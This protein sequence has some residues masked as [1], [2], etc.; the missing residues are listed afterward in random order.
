MAYITEKKPAFTA[1]EAILRT[2]RWMH[3]A[4]PLL[5]I[6]ALLATISAVTITVLWL[7]AE[8]NGINVDDRL[9]SLI[10]A[11]T[12][13]SMLVYLTVAFGCERSLLLA[14]FTRLKIVEDPK[15]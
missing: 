5:V 1:A 6:A 12:G 8:I 15:K 10:L 14:R 11:W 9:Y 13:A 4:L 2:L 7:L 3:I